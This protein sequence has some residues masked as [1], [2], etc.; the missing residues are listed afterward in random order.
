MKLTTRKIRLRLAWLGAP[1]FL[2][3][4]APTPATLAAGAAL[5]AAGVALRAWAAGTIVKNAV[6]TM[7]GPYAYTRNPL[8]LGSFLI[9]LG[10]A[11]AGA[12]LDV[13]AVYLVAY[14]LIYGRS[15]RSEAAGLERRFG[16]AYRVYAQNVPLFLPRLRPYRA[17][18]RA[19]S[20]FFIDRYLAHREYQAPLGILLG[21]LGLAAKM[22]LG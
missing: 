7:T 21:F 10:L 1:V 3:L 2:L 4:A 19:R 22:M 13:L 18:D 16:A 9:G 14:A 15:M 8:Y 17:D 5:A 11:V 20:H 6:L 12:R